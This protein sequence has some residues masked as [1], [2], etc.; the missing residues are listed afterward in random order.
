M[1]DLLQ[2]CY[3]NYRVAATQLNT[4]LG[5]D[6]RQR[7]QD[8]YRSTQRP[9]EEAKREDCKKIAEQMQACIKKRVPPS[10]DDLDKWAAFLWKI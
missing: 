7:G 10:V 4:A 6:V 1:S 9:I 3:E 2:A 5:D 8:Y